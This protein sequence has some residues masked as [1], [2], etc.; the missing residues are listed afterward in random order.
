MTPQI[1]SGQPCPG[2]RCIG[3]IRL[4]QLRSLQIEAETVHAAAADRLDA[5]RIALEY[6][7]AQKEPLEETLRRVIREE[8]GAGVRPRR[9]AKTARRSKE[10]ADKSSRKRA[11]AGGSKSDL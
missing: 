10:S 5:A 2:Q 8:V 6:M 7:A 4:P 1:G 3:E 11:A 9:A